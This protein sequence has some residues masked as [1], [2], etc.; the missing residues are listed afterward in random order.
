MSREALPGP[1]AS[2]QGRGSTQ[3]DETDPKAYN[4]YEES[5]VAESWPVSTQS[6][7]WANN[8]KRTRCREPASFKFY[9][10]ALSDQ[11][12]IYVETG[13]DHTKTGCGDEAKAAR[14]AKDSD[15]AD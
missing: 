3:T 14:D 5:A 11:V 12:R 10:W 1:E 4:F 13:Q 15:L 8:M 7:T 6:L 9:I 2:K